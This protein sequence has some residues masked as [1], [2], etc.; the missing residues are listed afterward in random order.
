MRHKLIHGQRVLMAVAACLLLA[1]SATVAE[2]QKICHLVVIADT[3]DRQIGDSVGV[4]AYH[5]KSLFKS[6]VARNQLQLHELVGNAV[7]RRGILNKI[8]QVNQSMKTEDTLI[9]FFAGHGAQDSS[10][11]H[12]VELSSGGNVL[13]SELL[14]QMSQKDVR[15]KILLTDTCSVMKKLD[16]HAAVMEAPV[17]TTTSPAF[18]ELCWKPTGIVDISSSKLG[19]VAMG[20]NVQGG[21]FTSQLTMFL[22]Q[23]ADRP[24]NWATV[25]NSVRQRTA[26]YFREQHPN[27]L[28]VPG[29]GRQ[30]TQT[31]TSRI[32]IEDGGGGTTPP[33]LSDGPRFGVRVVRAGSRGVLITEVMP[34]SPATNINVTGIQ[35]S[36]ALESGDRIISING[37]PINSEADY[38]RA[39]DNSGQMMRFEVLNSRDGQTY[40]ASV[41][42]RN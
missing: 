35:G 31:V 37:R 32:S 25:A 19:E 10:R 24:L 7:T 3:N 8:A 42:L 18:V 14:G 39:V 26:N 13:R 22:S 2:A 9:V 15:L 23:N 38:A 27:G 34:N 30:R 21:Y 33:P 6:N 29:V 40:S 5:M 11:G 41:R 17:A 12:Y 20:D 16:V 1:M 36:V 28:D 4:D